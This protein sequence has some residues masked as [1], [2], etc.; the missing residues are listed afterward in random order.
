MDTAVDQ[1]SGPAARR[2]AWVYVPY[3]VL[4]TLAQFLVLLQ[5][6]LAGQ[7]LS[8]KYGALQWHQN[9]A[10][11]IDM[12]LIVA[13][14]AAVL[15]KWP[16]H[17]PF[18]PIF[19]PPGLLVLTYTQNQTGFHRVLA[20][21]VPLGVLII[22]VMVPLTIWTWLPRPGRSDR[23]SGSPELGAR[24]REDGRHS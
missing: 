1:E 2:P 3:R 11:L 18:W 16:G 23:T 21:H 14:V 24:D 10:A 17:G 7:F 4:I 20:L 12:V 8:G 19:V 9:I 6:V 15:I 22:L 13:T 5:P